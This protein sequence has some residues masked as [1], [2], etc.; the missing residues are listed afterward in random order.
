MPKV[1][2]IRSIIFAISQERSECSSYFLHTDNITT[3]NI[4]FL[5]VDNIFFDGPGQA[6]SKYTNKIA[7]SLQY[8]KKS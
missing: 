5:Q 1:L 7:L 8:C 4:R 2:K 6:C 3:D